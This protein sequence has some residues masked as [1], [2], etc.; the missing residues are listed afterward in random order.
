MFRNYVIRNFP[1]LE[2]DFDAL[3]DYQLF[4]KMVSYMKKAL[5]KIDDFEDKLNKYE[6]YFE[7]LNVQE[8]INNKLEEMATSGELEEIIAL[9]LAYSN[10]LGFDTISDMQESQSLVN[11]SICKCLGKTNYLNGDGNYYKI[12]NKE[13]SDVIDGENIL[14]VNNP[15]LV[16]VKIID[17]SIENKY[18]LDNS[19]QAT[20]YKDL[21]LF[22]EE[23]WAVSG[24][25]IMKINNVPKGICIAN[26]WT[27]GGSG[28]TKFNIVTFDFTNNN[29]SNI[30]TRAEL[31]D[32][33][34]NSICDIGNNKAFICANGYNYIYDLAN[35]TNTVVSE[36]LPYFSMVA[37]DENGNIYGAQD[38]DYTTN[39]V[40]NALY[41]LDV[42]NV[43]DTV[44]LI[45]TKTIPNLREKLQENEQGM[46]IYNGLLIFPSFSNCKLCIY[47]FKTLDYIKTQLFTAPYIVEFEDGYVY[48]NELYICDS[49][50]RIFKPNIYNKSALGGYN[51]SC[52]TKSLTDICLL[53][54]PIKITNGNSATIKFEKYMTFMNYNSGDTGTIGKQLESIT[55]YCAL[56]NYTQSAGVH[57][58]VP[59]NIP[60]YKNITVDGETISWYAKHW[61]TYWQ[62]FT[63][64]HHYARTDISGTFN[65]GG[66]DSIP[67]FIISVDSDKLN[68]EIVGSTPTYEV[69][70][71]EQFDFY[72]TKIIGHRKVGMN[73]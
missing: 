73:I 71:D 34:A 39:Q 64:E 4:C 59:I 21:N 69:T 52:V 23:G 72:I 61:T 45:D 41:L 65:F 50:G 44:T 36:E 53:D 28:G 17:H 1:F 62:E 70:H 51:A 47:D 67:T 32:G 9:F 11:G 12:R 55:I 14:S 63:N 33:H 66:G 42:D 58:L 27:E 49:L 46:V 8:E 38:Y 57:N 48:E 68:T 60:M 54:T 3:T 2:D 40:V 29:V 10:I 5:I 18:L 20:L 13:E 19:I 56:R 43:N 16:A 26:D 7:N 22:N 30:V 35:N 25:L 15:D 37:N 6:N 24:V 31:L